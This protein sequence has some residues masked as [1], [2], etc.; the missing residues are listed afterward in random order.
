[1]PNAD[2][3]IDFCHIL[4]NTAV[5]ELDDERCPECGL[6]YRMVGRRH[7]CRGRKVDGVRAGGFRPPVSSEGSRGSRPAYHEVPKRA[8]SSTTPSVGGVERG[9]QEGSTPAP[10]QRPQGGVASTPSEANLESGEAV[11][12]RTVNAPTTGSNPVSP[13]KEYHRK[14]RPLRKNRDKTLAATKPW[15]ALEISERTYYRW[16]AEGKL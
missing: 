16:K 11:T 5:M 13:A 8:A 4:P 7:N 12:Q 10:G 14:G 3:A 6:L 15:E 2:T 1:M 9:T